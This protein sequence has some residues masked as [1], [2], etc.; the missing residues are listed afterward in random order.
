MIVQIIS[1]LF[2]SWALLVNWWFGMVVW[3]PGILW[4]KGSVILGAP[5]ESQTT[6]LPLVDIPSSDCTM[7]WDWMSGGTG[8]AL[9]SP[10]WSST[11]G[12][13]CWGNSRGHWWSWKEGKYA[14]YARSTTILSWK[15][16]DGWSDMM[17]PACLSYQILVK[18]ITCMYLI[19]C[20]YLY[21][22]LSSNSWSPS[23]DPIRCKTLTWTFNAQL[24]LREWWLSGAS[25]QAGITLWEYSQRYVLLSGR[26]WLCNVIRIIA[27]LSYL[28]PLRFLYFF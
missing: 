17:L 21:C 27:A 13:G 11:P 6:N 3:I 26:Y 7:S 12:N 16:F 19:Y 25:V 14:K 9:G 10:P 20:Q 4:W 23:H 1:S 15:V 24:L 28:C 5:I 8:M 18:P 2:V 22:I